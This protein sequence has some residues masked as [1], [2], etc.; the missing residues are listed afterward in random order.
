M[1]EEG[2]SALI[3]GQLEA[4]LVAYGLSAI[5]T[6]FIALILQRLGIKFRVSKDDEEKGLDIIE[7]G[8]ESYLERTGS[9][10]IN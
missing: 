5:G 9:P 7:H 3:F 1:I 4:V 8:E 2:R 10:S 6:V